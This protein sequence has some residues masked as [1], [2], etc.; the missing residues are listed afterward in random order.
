[1][2]F[3]F[4][5]PKQRRWSYFVL[6]GEFMNQNTTNKMGTKPIFPLLMSMAFPPMIS[7]LIQAM[8]N[9]VD[10]M[11]VAWISEEAL[12]AVS[13]AFPLQNFILAVAVGTGVGVNSYISRKLGEKNSQ[14]ANSAV[15][16]GLIL[17]GVSALVFVVLGLFL[18]KP[19]FNLFTN[20]PEVLKMGT[21][22]GYIIILL[23]FGVFIHI[24]IEKILQA[25]GKMIYPMIL[26]AVGAV[27]NIILDPILI[28]GLFGLPAMGVKGA[29][30]ATVIGQIS[31]M[32]LSVII[33]VCQKHD[34]KIEIKHF[35]FKLRTVKEIYAVGIPSILMISLGSILVMGLNAILITF[36][37]LAVSLFGIYFKLQ[38]FIFM[39]VNGLIQGAMP[40][41]GYNY[42]ASNKKR[43][44]GT[45]KASL[46]VS[47]VIM[48]FGNL[49]F[50]MFP[51]QLLLMFNASKEMLDLGS[52]TLRI[53]SYSYIAAAVG[54]VFSTLFQAIGK[55]FYSL[56]IS[57]LRQLVIIL[58]L[59]YL[60]AKTIG[61]TGVWIS[62]PIA[63]GISAV[64]AI[65]LFIHVYKTEPIFKKDSSI[66]ESSTEMLGLEE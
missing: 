52:V 66:Q 48:A 18:T 11:F 17:A 42:G 25:T 19:F 35:K 56:V 30:I 2:F 53:I 40:I 51:E 20:S 55:G 24:A 39:P 28:F 29:A 65:L 27:I 59:A 8:Y 45:L 63:E 46:I 16:H 58:P 15:T 23:S 50:V 14:E 22:Y 57:L 43:L 33:L 64:I 32:G 54:F 61:L 34:V 5:V 4:L 37:N 44:I 47:T 9:I 36:S 3:C 6:K 62:F 26:Q 7:M 49:L 31:A 13:L 12:T 10:S 1:M 60:L 21:E 41:M 38:T